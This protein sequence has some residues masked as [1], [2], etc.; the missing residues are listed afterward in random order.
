MSR[1][2]N[3]V[4]TKLITAWVEVGQGVGVGYGGVVALAVLEGGLSRAEL[5][6]NTL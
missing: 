2:R 5:K 4:R 6:E 1:E 3:G